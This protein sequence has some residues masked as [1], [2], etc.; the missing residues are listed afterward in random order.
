VIAS[1]P[2]GAPSEVVDDVEEMIGSLGPVPG[3]LPPNT[4]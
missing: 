2:L 3:T 4:F 1:W